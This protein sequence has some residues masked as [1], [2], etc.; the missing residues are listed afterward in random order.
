V[1]WKFSLFL[2]EAGWVGMVT[3][4]SV[5][6]WSRLNIIIIDKRVLR[7]VLAMI[8][9]NAFIW[10]T[11]LV[12]L[13]FGLA[14]ANMSQR[15][16]WLRVLN[17]FE[18]VQITMFTVQESIITLMYIW[19]TYKILVDRIVQHRQTTRRVLIL[20]FI[21]QTTVLLMDIVIITLDLAG[22]FTLKAI[23]HSWVY[24]IKLELEFVVLNQL[25]EIAKSG[26][27]GLSSIKDDDVPDSSLTESAENTRNCQPPI[28][29]PDSSSAL[30][31]KQPEGWWPPFPAE[32]YTSSNSPSFASSHSKSP[33]SKSPRGSLT[34]RHNNGLGLIRE[35][36]P[37]GFEEMLSL[38]RIGVIPDTSD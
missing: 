7:G 34:L 33:G 36:Q 16:A 24:G 31:G 35:D 15:Q 11:A 4:F 17:P 38:D 5:V 10:H 29:S 37:L 13:Q 6:L 21:V 26:V 8:I 32:G 19:A 27:P 23:L 2:A 12:I 20:L 9:L 18:R 30:K 22:Y 14:E 3:G 28:S 1:P 25:V